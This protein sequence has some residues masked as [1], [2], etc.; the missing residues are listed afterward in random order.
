[1]AFWNLEAIAVWW[2]KLMHDD[3]SWPSHGRYRCTTCK[4]SYPVA[5]EQPFTE[6]SGER[7]KRLA[8]Q[9]S[10]KAKPAHAS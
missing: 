3:I 4:R 5:W 7:A 2:C 1:M 8:R 9:T 6:S 10:E